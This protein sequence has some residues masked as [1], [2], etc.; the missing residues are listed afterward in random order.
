M[1]EV[2]GGFIVS[3]GAIGFRGD[4]PPSHCDIYHSLARGGVGIF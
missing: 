1:R 2:C 3:F 4:S